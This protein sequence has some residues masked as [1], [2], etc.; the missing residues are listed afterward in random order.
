M[1]AFASGVGGKIKLHWPG[2]SPVEKYPATYFSGEGWV[3]VG[4]AKGRNR[5]RSIRG[6]AATQ[7]GK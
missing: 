7:A 2:R 5:S 4:F 1:L 6:G 3:Q